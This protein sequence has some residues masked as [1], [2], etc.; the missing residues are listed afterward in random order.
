[1]DKIDRIK[2]VDDF[3]KWYEDLQEQVNIEHKYR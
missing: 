1:M 2:V 3:N